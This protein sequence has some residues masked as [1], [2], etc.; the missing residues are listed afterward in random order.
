MLKQAMADQS[1]VYSAQILDMFGDLKELRREF[2]AFR[3]H[4]EGEM[5]TLRA[6]AGAVRVVINRG[7]SVYRSWVNHLVW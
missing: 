2:E 1:T 6:T 7:P 4:T 5:K 3:K